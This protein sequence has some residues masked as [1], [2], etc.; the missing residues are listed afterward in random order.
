M[1]GRKGRKVQWILGSTSSEVVFS[2]GGS[3]GE[4]AHSHRGEN[5][6]QYHPVGVGVGE[7]DCLVGGKVVAQKCKR[8]GNL[9]H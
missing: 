6:D 8:G 7:T 5:F 9:Q 1:I 2:F 3:T 4:D